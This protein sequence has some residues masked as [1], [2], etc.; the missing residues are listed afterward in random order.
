MKRIWMLLVC[1]CLL[2]GC[3]SSR[4]EKSRL[5]VLG[6]SIDGN[7][8]INSYFNI[9]ADLDESWQVESEDNLNSKKEFT[10]N[11]SAIVVFYAHRDYGLQSANVLIE[12]I[13]YNSDEEDLIDLV[14]GSIRSDFEKQGMKNVSQD[15][16]RVDY[17][18]KEAICI[19]TTAFLTTNR[20]KEVPVF[21][22][23]YILEKN[24]YVAIINLCSLQEDHLEEMSS[25][26]YHLD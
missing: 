5:E 3:S 26:F 7:R 14:A 15:V 12:D 9:I 11:G 2:V 19:L 18:G 17:V 13:N 16:E 4:I 6:G 22:K 21:S 10:K 20:S 25:Y 24:R 8:Y 1:V 23:Q